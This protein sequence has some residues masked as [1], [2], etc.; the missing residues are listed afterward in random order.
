MTVCVHPNGAGALHA[1]G[2]Q[3]LGRSKGGWQR[4]LMLYLRLKIRWTLCVHNCR[5]FAF[6]R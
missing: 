4:R 2:E 5:C 1:S 3:S 6:A